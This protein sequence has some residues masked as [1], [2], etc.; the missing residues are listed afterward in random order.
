M[1]ALSQIESGSSRIRIYSYPVDPRQHP[2]D[3]RRSVKP[4]DSGTFGNRIQFMALRSL[5]GDYNKLLDQYT[6]KY[7]LGNIIWPSYPL[8]FRKD[9]PEVIQEL[10]RRNLYLFDIWGFVPG[11]VREAT[12]SNSLFLIIR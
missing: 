9:L 8:I 1:P 2:D 7:G 12:G 5:D 3:F 10:K 6:V 11:S 4:P